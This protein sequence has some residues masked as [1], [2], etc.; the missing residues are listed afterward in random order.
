MDGSFQKTFPIS[1]WRRAET[2]CLINYNIVLIHLPNSPNIVSWCHIWYWCQIWRS[3]VQS[4][5]LVHVSL[6]S[7]AKYLHSYG[8]KVTRLEIQYFTNNEKIIT[9]GKQWTEQYKN[10]LSRS[11]SVICAFGNTLKNVEDPITLECPSYPNI[12]FDPCIL[13]HSLAFLCVP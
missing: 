5:N 8:Y 12:P 2:T 6:L 13:K 9:L 3:P 1:N 7:T 11:R 4:C 10:F